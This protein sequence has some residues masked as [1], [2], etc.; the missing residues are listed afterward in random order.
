MEDIVALR[1]KLVTGEE[2][3]FLTWGRVLDPVDPEPLISCAGQHVD[4]WSLGGDVAGIELC[5]TLQEAAHAPYFF[6][7]FFR[8]CQRRVPYGGAYEE[9]REQMLGELQSGRE[10][11]YLGTP[12]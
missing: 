8:L 4:K 7:S 10:L 12:E 3:F 9:W 11:H 6:E 1:V 5:A 2:R